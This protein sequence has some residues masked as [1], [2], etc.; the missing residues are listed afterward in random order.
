MG[1]WNSGGKEGRKLISGLTEEN[2]IQA[3]RW[4]LKCEQ[5]STLNNHSKVVNDGF[6]SGKL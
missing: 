3:T 1:L 5:E 2:V 4:Y 6:V